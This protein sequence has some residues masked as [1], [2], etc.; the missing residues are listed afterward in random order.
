MNRSFFVH[1]KGICDSESIAE[2]T[3]IWAFAHVMKGAQI[4]RKCNI[5][6]HS[7]VEGKVTIGNGCTIKNGVAVWDAV[8]LEDDV[9]VG[10]YVVFTNDFRP[11]AFLKRGGSQ[12]LPTLLKKGCTLGANST[13]ICGV[14]IGQYAMVGAGSVVSKDVPAHTLVVGNPARLIGRVCFC[15]ERLNARDFCPQC[16]LVLSENS[17]EKTI[18]KLSTHAP[19]SISEPVAEI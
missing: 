16:R 5:G 14:T 4:G 13:I 10:P 1:E 17:V 8:T 11:R 7:Y 9:F 15:G 19:V 12:Y 18:Q 2:G 3:R 6:E